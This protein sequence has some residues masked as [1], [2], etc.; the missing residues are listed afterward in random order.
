[1]KQLN[2]MRKQDIFSS[3]A[4]LTF[5][6]GE[7]FFETKNL[8][9]YIAEFLSR[10]RLPDEVDLDDAAHDVLEAIEAHHGIFVERATGIHSFSHLTFQEYFTARYI[11]NAGTRSQLALIQKYLEQPKWKEVFVLVASLL[12]DADSFILDVLEKMVHLGF[13]DRYVLELRESSGLD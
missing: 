2:P 12:S 10:L 6:R 11:V 1:Y 7:Y 13:P 5:E 9:R 4:A 3:V 8:E